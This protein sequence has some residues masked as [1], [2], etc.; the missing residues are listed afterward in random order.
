M[1]HVPLPHARAV[2]ERSNVL[3]SPP[4]SSNQ[5]REH[6]IYIEFTVDKVIGALK[7]KQKQENQ[8]DN[9]TE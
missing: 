2:K 8:E 5:D 4:G 1:T 6:L 7:F 3:V 9:I